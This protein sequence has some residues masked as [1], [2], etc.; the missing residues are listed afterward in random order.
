MNAIRNA[1][2]IGSGCGN[3]GNKDNAN[4][5]LA[6]V[7]MNVNALS[8]VGTRA[9]CAARFVFCFTYQS[10][11]PLKP[12]GGFKPF[13]FNFNDVDL[14]PYFIKPFLRFVVKRFLKSI[15]KKGKRSSGEDTNQ[16]SE[17]AVLDVQEKVDEVEFDLAKPVEGEEAKSVESEVAGIEAVPEPQ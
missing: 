14:K 12:E 8:M 4:A 1:I 6:S 15:L 7:K 5:M 9:R 16:T 13:I 10:L 11:K 3:S 17:E 2:T